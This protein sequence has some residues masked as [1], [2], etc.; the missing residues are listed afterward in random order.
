MTPRRAAPV[1]S[2]HKSHMGT[3]SRKSRPLTGKSAKS[4]YKDA[5][6]SPALTIIQMMG[7]LHRMAGWSSKDPAHPPR[8]TTPGMERRP[9]A[10]SAA[11]DCLLT[12]YLFR[13]ENHQ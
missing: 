9:Q 11:A 13:S 12:L 2:T 4:P 1:T 5:A 7:R 6:T 3:V 8:R 10:R